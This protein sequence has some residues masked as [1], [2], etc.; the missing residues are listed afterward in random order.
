[1]AT[2]RTA[3]QPRRRERVER[4]LERKPAAMA[5]L[6]GGPGQRRPTETLLRKLLDFARRRGLGHPMTVITT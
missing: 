4:T 2:S 1:M 6:E 3:T 5:E